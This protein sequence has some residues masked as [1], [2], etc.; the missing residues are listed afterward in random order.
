[1]NLSPLFESILNRGGY[2]IG[3]ILL[4][5]RERYLQKTISYNIR[6]S[7]ILKYIFLSGHTNNLFSHIFCFKMY[8][9]VFTFVNIKHFFCLLQRLFDF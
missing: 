8:F 2:I 6:E 5:N 4:S 9:V 3:I 1:M 7:V